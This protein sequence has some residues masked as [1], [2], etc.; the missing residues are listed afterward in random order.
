M[1]LPEPIRSALKREG[2]SPQCWREI[3]AAFDSI[4]TTAPEAPP[5]PI[6]FVYAAVPAPAAETRGNWTIEQAKLLLA[7]DAYTSSGYS[8]AAA[9]ERLDVS[10]Q[11]IYRVLREH[12][13]ELRKPVNKLRNEINA[14]R[15]R[16][17]ALEE[18][19]EAQK[20]SADCDAG[21]GASVAAAIPDK[22]VGIC[23]HDRPGHIDGAGAAA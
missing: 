10:K 19:L 9:A 8:T 4:K 3:T 6:P 22:Y 15:A 11:T 18:K 7:L 12:G 17:K 2:A 1:P 23:A 20:E 21:S 14:L 16:L 13:I 5:E